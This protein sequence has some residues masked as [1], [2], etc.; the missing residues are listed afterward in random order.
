MACTQIW[1]ASRLSS[2]AE[3]ARSHGSHAACPH[4]MQHAACRG[5]SVCMDTP[6]HTSDTQL[7]C[8]A[9]SHSEQQHQSA[10]DRCRR[11]RICTLT[12]AAPASSRAVRPLPRPMLQSA[13]GWRVQKISHSKRGGQHDQGPCPFA[14]SLYS[15]LQTANTRQSIYHDPERAFTHLYGGL[16][17]HSLC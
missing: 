2:Q 16:Q 13:W 1:A 7:V 17:R 3:S 6:A 11:S 10:I 12:S 8:G 9:P 4:D 14:R 5:G 15:P